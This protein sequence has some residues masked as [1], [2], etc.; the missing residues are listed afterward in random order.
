MSNDNNLN[1]IIKSKFSP[2]HS[3]EHPFDEA[4][5]KSMRTMIDASRAKKK[6]TLFLI[7][8]LA[9]LL[10]AAGTAAIY[11]WKS[12]GAKSTSTSNIVKTNT[13]SPSTAT[14]TN[15]TINSTS[16]AIN[17][18]PAISSNNSTANVTNGAPVATNQSS[19]NV[20]MA[21]AAVNNSSSQKA[22]KNKKHRTK[23]ANQ[24][25]A[26]NNAQIAAD[27]K[28]R[29]AI[30]SEPKAENTIS[31]KESSVTPLTQAQLPVN[32]TPPIVPKTPA[33]PVAKVNTKAPDTATSLPQRFSDEPRIYN[34]KKQ[35][36]SIDAG[37]YFSGGWAT[38]PTTT[39]GSGF[40]YVVGVGYA[41]YLKSK[42]FI[43]TGIQFSDFG[44]LSSYSYN[45][46][47]TSAQNPNLINDS[48]ITTKRL[49]YLSI[50]VQFEKFIGH[51]SSLGLGG[52]VSY[53]LTS[54][55]SATTYQQL[56]NNPPV[57]YQSYSQNIHLNGY[58]TWTASA[59][60]LYRYTFNR[61]FS[62]YVMF[63]FM[64]PVENKAFFGEHLYLDNLGTKFLLSYT[65]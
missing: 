56:D 33:P 62:A 4:N 10:C 22:D 26:D 17:P 40:N 21:V 50:P 9:L 37:A 23:A 30:A 15:S 32:S 55:A 36:I 47:S 60:G 29:D 25:I 43:K 1:D 20:N 27:R 3:G 24:T 63:Y 16:R 28:M 61:H 51:K 7:G 65:L 31:G 44:H 19:A 12:E 34:G 6:R 41:H 5:W 14:T 18:S 8:S 64:T 49:Y 46:Q 59:Y 2:E 57:N 53:L 58:N 39:E 13:N 48:A 35:M 42:I 45:Y 38:S 54:T 11:E 52:S